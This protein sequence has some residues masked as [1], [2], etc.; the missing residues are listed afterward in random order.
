MLG[1]LNFLCLS[2]LV[3]KEKVF[4]KKKGKRFFK[5]KYFFKGAPFILKKLTL[6]KKGEPQLRYK[7][8]LNQKNSLRK[9]FLVRLKG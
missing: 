1:C 6:L 8:R 5:K 4:F 9:N 7:R 3:R 2:K